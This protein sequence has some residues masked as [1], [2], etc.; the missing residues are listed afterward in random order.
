MFALFF[1]LKLR[2][3]FLFSRKKFAK[4]RIEKMKQ[5]FVKPLS[6]IGVSAT[7]NYSKRLRF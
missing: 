1:L 7:L 5:R 4:Q 2:N 6:K 3:D